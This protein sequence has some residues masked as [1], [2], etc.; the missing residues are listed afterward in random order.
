MIKEISSLPNLGYLH[1]ELPESLFKR[2]L[3]EAEN[4]EK[5]N[6]KILC[7]LTEG[8]EHVPLHYNITKELEEELNKFVLS[9]AY[10][11]CKIYD[12]PWTHPLG[13]EPL[14]LTNLTNWI[15]VQKQ[16]EYIRTHMHD[17]IISYTTWLK[18]PNVDQKDQ[19]SFWFD[20]NGIIGNM[21]H[22]EIKL[23]QKFV[24]NLLVFPS[25]LEHTVYPF[26]NSSENRISISGNIGYETK[27][28]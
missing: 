24:G 23:N 14:K 27:G 4:A 8:K 22:H 1:T 13:R 5:D 28:K 3:E 15:N 21:M 10:D 19:A 9:C 25:A 7:G 16:G 12:Y 17:G 26:Y 2:L 20:Y 11:F 18:I 6:D